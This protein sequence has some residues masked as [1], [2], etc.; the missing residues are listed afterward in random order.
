[1]L[2]AQGDV[3]HDAILRELRDLAHATRR[4][5]RAV[6]EETLQRGLGAA[7]RPGRRERVQ[8]ETH[9]VG[10]KAG[11]RAMSMN[12]LYDQIEAEAHRQGV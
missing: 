1:M 10:I 2:A 9:P 7:S 6:V 12:Q 3:I 11:L 4:P 8:I 5:F